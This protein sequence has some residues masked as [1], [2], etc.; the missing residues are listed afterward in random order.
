MI[1]IIRYVFYITVCAASVFIC[2]TE[3][4]IPVNACVRCYD[5]KLSGSFKYGQCGCSF[6]T[7]PV[8]D[9]LLRL[10]PAHNQIISIIIIFLIITVYII[11]FKWLIKYLHTYICRFMYTQLYTQFCGH[12]YLYGNYNFTCMCMLQMNE[13]FEVF[14][15]FMS[16]LIYL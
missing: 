2:C 6:K 13:C 5:V 10:P 11:I 12:R 8:N 15:K 9:N 1:C 16:Y 14:W 4:A 3:S 7:N